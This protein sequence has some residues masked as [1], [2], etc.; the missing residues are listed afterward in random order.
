MTL[1]HA[2]VWLDH[3]Q[4]EI[5]QFDPEHVQA[6]KVKSRTNH[7]RTHGNGVRTEHEFFGLVCNA[8]Q[9]VPEVLI[10]GSKT[11]LKDFQHFVDQHRPALAPHVFGYEV[12]DHPSPAQ[13]VALARRVFVKADRMAGVPTP[14]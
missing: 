7:T 4:A 11:S 2:V 8:L 3:H 10:T 14:S 13:L 9:A 6:S 5:L 12:V 1:F